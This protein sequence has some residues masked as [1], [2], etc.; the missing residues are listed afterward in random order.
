MNCRLLHLSRVK[1]INFLFEEIAIVVY[2][3]VSIR[4][5]IPLKK[6]TVDEK[7]TNRSKLFS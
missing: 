3:V 6:G 2:I 1:K 7:Y 4:G 5:I